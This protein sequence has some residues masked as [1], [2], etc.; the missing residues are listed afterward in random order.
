MRHDAMHKSVMFAAAAAAAALPV[1]RDSLK[2]FYDRAIFSTS[3]QQWGAHSLSHIILCSKPRRTLHK[4]THT[5]WKPYLYLYFLMHPCSSYIIYTYVRYVTYTSIQRWSGVHIHKN[6]RVR[7]C[8]NS[9]S[10]VCVCV[11]ASLYSYVPWCSEYF[12]TQCCH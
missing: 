4:H 12:C 7:I 2:I 1:E 3:S 11:F 5:H 10:H 6:N 8:R 9:Y